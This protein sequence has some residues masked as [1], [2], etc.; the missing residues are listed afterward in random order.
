MI[1]PMST[2]VPDATGTPT[3]V[4]VIGKPPTRVRAVWNGEMRFDGHREPGG[5]SIRLDGRG[6]T[7][8]S[9]VDTLLLALASC[10]GIDVVEIL[11][12]RRTP[13]QSLEVG[14]VGERAAATPSRVTSAHLTFHIGGEDVDRTHADRAIELAVNK[15]CSV[16]DSLDPNMP[17]TWTLLLNGV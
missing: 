15:Y 2:A 4:P 6:V 7:G 13:V 17:V 11:A 14:V 5:P 3:S 16:K 9:P 1:D 8:P 12:K 10:A